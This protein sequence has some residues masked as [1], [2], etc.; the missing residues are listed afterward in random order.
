MAERFTNTGGMLSRF[1]SNY[2]MLAVLLLLCAYYSWATLR[3]Q[4]P[5]GAAAGESLARYIGDAQSAPAAGL[6]VARDTDD[7]RRVVGAT[8]AGLKERGFTVAGKV[9]GEPRDVKAEMNRLAGAGTKVDVVAATPAAAR[10]TVYEKV[11]AAQPS[12]GTPKVMFPA[13]RVW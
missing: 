5:R 10:W 6:I 11:A 2:G 12:L 8:E 9:L 3:E 13:A 1:F 7:D 4:Q